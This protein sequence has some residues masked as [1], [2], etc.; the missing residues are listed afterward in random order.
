MNAI[1]IYVAY[2]FV[3][4][5]AISAGLVGGLASHLGRGGPAVVEFGTVALVWLLLYHMY[6]QKIFLRI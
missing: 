2:H 1:T 4:F 6:R 3:P 5:R